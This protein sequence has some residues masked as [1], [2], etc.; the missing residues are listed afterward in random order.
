MFF[1][2]NINY[3]KV[4]NG[5]VV[6]NTKRYKSLLDAMVG[7][8]LIDKHYKKLESEALKLIQTCYLVYGKYDTQKCVDK[9]VAITKYNYDKLSQ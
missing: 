7:Y 9:L 4:E 3:I 1:G 5:K 2:K 8:L 6:Y